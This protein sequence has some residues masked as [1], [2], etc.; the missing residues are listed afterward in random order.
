[1][2][3]KEFYEK[4]NNFSGR[5]FSEYYLSP[6]IKCKY[7]IILDKVKNIH[8]FESAIDLGC[9]G[10]SFLKLYENVRYKLFFDIA[11]I[12]LTQY[13]KRENNNEFWHPLCGDMIKL[14][15]RDNSIDIVFA[16]DTLEHLKDD[17]LAIS[18]ISRILKQ[19]G[20]AI[21]SI[22]HRMK[23]YSTQDKMIGH[24]RRYEINKISDLFKKYR[25]KCLTYFG[26]YGQLMRF[27]FLQKLKP[28]KTEKNL[29]KLRFRYSSNRLFR[30]FWNIIVY[31]GS[32]IMKLDAK[33]QPMKKKMNIGFIFMKI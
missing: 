33:Y 8:N 1:M 27:T 30:I 9:S 28:K 2:N 29:K 4:H 21:I 7:N 14:P 11:N 19:K 5:T 32:K 25:L 18:E 13:S 26:I 3:R 15:Y 10:N 20:I 24:F 12:P 16:L 31:F 23:Y 22:P 17:E 6:G